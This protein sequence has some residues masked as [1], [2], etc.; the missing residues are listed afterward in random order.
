MANR[1][2]RPEGAPLPLVDKFLPPHLAE[3]AE[4]AFDDYVQNRKRYGAPLEFVKAHALMFSAK[5]ILG[6]E[7]GRV[8]DWLGSL[9]REQF[10]VGNLEQSFAFMYGRNYE[11]VRCYS[12]IAT[13]TLRSICFGVCRFHDCNGVQRSGALYRWYAPDNSRDADD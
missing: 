2:N 9:R 5:I 11:L 7:A 6:Y 1:Q 13:I 10:T 12:D 4:A 3:G 8:L